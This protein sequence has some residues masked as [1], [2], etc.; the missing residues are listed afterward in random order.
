M[1]TS[2]SGGRNGQKRREGSCVVL[3]PRTTARLLVMGCPATPGAPSPVASSTCS[4]VP[5]SP[6]RRPTLLDV[7]Q[8]PQQHVQ[9][10]GQR[11]DPNVSRWDCEVR[12]YNSSLLIQAFTSASDWLAAEKTC[13][14]EGGTLAKIESAA[15]NTAVLGLMG[16][17]LDGDNDVISY[18]CFHFQE[19]RLGGLVFRTSSTREHS[20]GLTAQLWEATPT[21][22]TTSRI[23]L[24]RV[25]YGD[26]RNIR[27]IIILIIVISA[28]CRA[29]NSRL[30][31]F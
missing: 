24:A 2:A 7:S 27:D 5:P 14:S 16:D 8:V 22:L 21:G 11:K 17:I 6:V 4:R 23:M 29:Q 25:R 20:P 15:E 28:L 19:D 12:F 31:F 9:L 30:F 3:W 10:D 26:M 18:Y 1:W 13:N